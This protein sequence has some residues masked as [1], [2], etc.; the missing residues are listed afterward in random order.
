MTYRLFILCYKLYR[1]SEN[2]VELK[3]EY[4]SKNKRA[5]YALIGGFARAGLYV[6]G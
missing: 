1:R 6:F 2:V 3:D 4:A 5:M